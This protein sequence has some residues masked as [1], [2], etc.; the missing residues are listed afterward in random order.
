MTGFVFA[1]SG[2][3]LGAVSVFWTWGFTGENMVHRRPCIHAC[4]HTRSQTLSCRHT[5]SLPAPLSDCCAHDV[6][7][8]ASSLPFAWAQ[9]HRVLV[10]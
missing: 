2:L 9:A 8:A 1:A 5:R 7:P 6:S 10:F 4:M 3:A